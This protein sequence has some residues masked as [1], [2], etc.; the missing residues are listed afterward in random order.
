ML[1]VMQAYPRPLGRMPHGLVPLLRGSDAGNA[2][3]LAQLVEDIAIPL[4]EQ[5]AS[6]PLA[7]DVEHDGI[8]A[9]D[10]G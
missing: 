10:M 2:R 4:I 8:V 1:G 7:L 9:R 3:Q 6:V 5:A